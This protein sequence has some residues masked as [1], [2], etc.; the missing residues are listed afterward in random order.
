[1]SRPWNENKPGHNGTSYT[2]NKGRAMYICLRNKFDHNK[3]VDPEM[4]F[5]VM[6]HEASHIANYNG[7]GHDQRFWMVFKFILQNAVESGLYHPVD[8]SKYPQDYCGLHVDWNP[9]LDKTLPEIT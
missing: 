7:W 4:L 6:L 9:L 2:V 3:L 1:M 8:Y 5:F